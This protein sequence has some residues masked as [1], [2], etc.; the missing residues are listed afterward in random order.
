M[1]AHVPVAALAWVFVHAAVEGILQH[2]VQRTYIECLI[3]S[4]LEVHLVL[5]SATDALP[6]P[7]FVCD[8]IE[9]HKGS[10]K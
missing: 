1:F 6:T 7:S 4:R 2:L 5:E 9:C 8:L 3:V 10:S